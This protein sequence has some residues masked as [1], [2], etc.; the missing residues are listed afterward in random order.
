MAATLGIER[1][2]ARPFHA[3]KSFAGSDKRLSVN[4]SD[5]IEWPSS[6]IWA[7]GTI[8]GINLITSGFTRL[9]YSVDARRVLDTIG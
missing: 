3:A 2:P 5:S 8:L 6:S 1:P 4:S 9:M 7:I